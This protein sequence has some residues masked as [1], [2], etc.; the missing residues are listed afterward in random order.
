MKKLM[1]IIFATL[2]TLA[3]NAESIVLE[4][5]NRANAVLNIFVFI[6]INAIIVLVIYFVGINKTIRLTIGFLFT[7]FFLFLR[8]KYEYSLWESIYIPLIFF[9]PTLIGILSLRERFE[10]MDKI[11]EFQKE[12]FDFS[13]SFSFKNGN[14]YIAGRSL[15]PKTEKDLY[16]YLSILYVDKNYNRLKTI[17]DGIAEAE[18][19]SELK[20]IRVIKNIDGICWMIGFMDRK[21]GKITTTD[22]KYDKATPLLP[23][24][25]CDIELGEEYLMYSSLVYLHGSELPT[26]IHEM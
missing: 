20:K 17:I 3:V 6:I 15:F 7:T 4:D 23:H 24:R 2:I 12:G 26:M 9:S 19:N 5:N 14:K 25:L 18:F 16:N 22:F 1:L 8:I 10:K 11:K 21:T 13:N